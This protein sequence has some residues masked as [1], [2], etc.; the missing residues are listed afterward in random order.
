MSTPP[1]GFVPA[2]DNPG[3]NAPSWDWDKGDAVQGDYHGQRIV[4]VKGESRTIHDITTEDGDVVVWGTTVL[5]RKLQAVEAGQE[6]WIRRLGKA[7]G[8][9][10]REYWDFELFVR[11]LAETAQAPE[12]FAAA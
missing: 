3:N 1:E 10:G 12:G 11:P 2:D 8:P 6:V 5:D 9:N 7:K 4:Q